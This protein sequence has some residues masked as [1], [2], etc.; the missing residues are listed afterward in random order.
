MKTAGS[1]LLHVRD[2]CYTHPGSQRGIANISLTASDGEITAIKGRSG[3]GKST[4]LACIAGVL[5]PCSG[6][7]TFAESAEGASASSRNLPITGMTP[8]VSARFSLI[9]QNCALFEHLSTWENVALGWGPPRQALRDRA[10]SELTPLGVAELADAK[11][12]AL[13]LGQRQR[14][15]IAAALAMNSDVILADEPTGSLDQVNTTRVLKSLRLAAERG[16][17]VVISSHDD[18]VW[19][20]ADRVI[21]MNAANNSRTS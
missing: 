16:A 7:V 11:P 10:I 1:R 3:E 4:L 20:F 2:M 12:S 18:A 19:S 14:V 5:T 6:T 9:L 13:S 17:A 8:G 21:D 15:A